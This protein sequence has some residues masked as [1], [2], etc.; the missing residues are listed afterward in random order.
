MLSESIEMYVTSKCWTMNQVIQRLTVRKLY[1]HVKIQSSSPFKEADIC[2]L[3]AIRQECDTDV[4][5]T[6]LRA[7]KEMCG[8]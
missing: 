2:F 5:D 8:C 4:S 1:A 7:D 3:S 6:H